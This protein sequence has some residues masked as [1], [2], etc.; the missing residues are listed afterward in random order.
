MVG[1]D[2]VLAF[3]PQSHLSAEGPRWQPW[4]ARA[5]PVQVPPLA[6]GWTVICHGLEDDAEQAAGF[7]PAPGLDHVLFPGQ[8][9]S[10]LVP[11]LK[12]RG[13]LAGLAEA[14]LAGDRRRLLR[15]A[16]SAGGRLRRGQLPR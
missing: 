7:A 9:H 8:T 13:V 11:H 1:A 16:A 4:A 12:A 10:G 14:A 3:G 2:V 6:A 5:A 15:I